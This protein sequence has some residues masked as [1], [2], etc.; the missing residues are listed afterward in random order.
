MSSKPSS[1]GLS[2]GGDTD[3]TVAVD[4]PIEL[5]RVDSQVS[6]KSA[7]VGGHG[8]DIDGSTDGGDNYSSKSED[9]MG[10]RGSRANSRDY[11]NEGNG[12]MGEDGRAGGG[13]RHQ[14]FNN[15]QGSGEYNEILANMQEQEVNMKKIKVKMGRGKEVGEEEDEVVENTTDGVGES[16]NPPQQQQ[17]VRLGEN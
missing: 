7:G 3:A 4:K 16:H 2:E 17:Q 15:R 6:N 8:E 9:T 11:N 5:K 10:N 13:D 12:G 1:E 14:G